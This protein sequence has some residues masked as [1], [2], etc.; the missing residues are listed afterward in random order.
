MGYGRSPKLDQDGVLQYDEDLNT[1]PFIE[2]SKALAQDA[3]LRLE[4]VEGELPL[5]PDVGIDLVGLLGTEFSQRRIR[6]EFRREL[7]SAPRIQTVTRIS[8]EGPDENRQ[9]TV[10]IEG[11]AV[12]GE[13]FQAKTLAQVL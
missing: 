6:T 9:V 7:E 8:V 3:R 2:G 5:H 13:T 11:R 12:D 4:T 10:I 1:F